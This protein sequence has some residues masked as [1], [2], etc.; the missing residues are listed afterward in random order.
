MDGDEIEGDARQVM[1]ATMQLLA[2]CGPP[3]V[4]VGWGGR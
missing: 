3:A 1:S 2:G 4:A